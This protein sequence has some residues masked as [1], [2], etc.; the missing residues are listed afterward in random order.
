LVGWDAG[1]EAARALHDALPL[2][3]KA[4]SVTVL[5]INP[6][7]GGNGLGDEPG[8]DLAR[9]LARHGL[10]VTAVQ[11]TSNGLNASDVLLNHAA[12][13]SSDLIVVGGYGH[14][15]MREILLGGVTR[16]LLRH[17]TVPVLMSH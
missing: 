16:D 10:R 9:H 14:A 4:E 7:L 11:T 8:A 13:L 5:A 3:A 1:R 6:K 15:R 2:I 17:A 12:D